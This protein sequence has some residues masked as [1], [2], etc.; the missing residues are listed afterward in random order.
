M[1]RQPKTAPP[2]AKFRRVCE[3][4]L[5]PLTVRVIDG[6]LVIRCEKCEAGS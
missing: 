2:K 3:A 4:C 1:S 5:H 6:R